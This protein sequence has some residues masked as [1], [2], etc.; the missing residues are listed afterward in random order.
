MRQDFE[1][2]IFYYAKMLRF[3]TFLLPLIMAYELNL[4]NQDLI[5][6]SY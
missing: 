4:N 6:L 1:W 3:L 2:M 5:F